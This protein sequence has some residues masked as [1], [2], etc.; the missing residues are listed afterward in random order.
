MHPIASKHIR[1]HPN[2]S[3]RV[4]KLSKTSENVKN[5]TKPSRKLRDRGANFSDVALNDFQRFRMFL[6]TFRWNSDAFGPIRTLSDVFGRVRMHSD[7]FRCNSDA[8]GHVRENHKIL[9]F[10]EKNNPFWTFGVVFQSRGLTFICFLRLGGLTFI[11]AF[12]SEA[13]LRD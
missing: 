2:R 7:A 10:F 9:T 8:F 4:R 11:G 13:A 5:C 12:F 3:K 1:T 6:D